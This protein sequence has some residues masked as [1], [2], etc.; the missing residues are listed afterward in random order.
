MLRTI[1]ALIA[2]VITCREDSTLLITVPP[3]PREG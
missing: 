1:A 2:W 3:L